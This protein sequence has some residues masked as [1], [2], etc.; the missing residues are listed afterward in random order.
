MVR[1]S[2]TGNEVRD[3]REGATHHENSKVGEVVA[4]AL[5]LAAPCHC[6][7]PR[8]VPAPRTACA[9]ERE[10]SGEHNNICHGL[11]DLQG[12]VS[13]ERGSTRVG[14]PSLPQAK[15]TTHPE[16]RGKPLG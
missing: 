3:L 11:K 1:K 15:H 13:M 5:C 9:R 12:Q 14:D 6:G 10:R 4:P 16:G 8:A 7:T 2:T